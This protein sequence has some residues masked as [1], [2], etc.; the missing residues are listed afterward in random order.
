MFRISLFIARYPSATY[1]KLFK[2]IQKNLFEVDSK[3]F[4]LFGG[5]RQVVPVHVGFILSAL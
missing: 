4:F 1:L 3:G 5:Y 2:L